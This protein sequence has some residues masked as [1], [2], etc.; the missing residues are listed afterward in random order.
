MA[1]ELASLVI[2]VA[3]NIKGA[4]NGFKSLEQ[5]SRTVSKRI[6]KNL[7]E[8]K[9]TKFE[10]TIFNARNA[11][12]GFIGA[13][14][15][16]NVIDVAVQFESIRAAFA[17]MTGSL[18]GGAKAFEFVNEVAS[19]TGV[20][21]LAGA[22][23][24]RML[25]GAA[26]G[27]GYT[28]TQL[29]DTFLAASKASL[30]LGLRT[31]DTTGIMRAF[32]QIMS[33]GT[34]Q[35]EELKGQLGDRLPGAVG[36]AAR[37]MGVSNRRLLEMMENAELM[38]KEFIPKFVEAMDERFTP[39]VQRMQNT[40]GYAI[41]QMDIAVERLKNSIGE[42]GLLEAIASVGMEVAD[43]LNNI[44]KA[45]VTK[46]FQEMSFLKDI[47]IAV[48]DIVLGVK[49]T[50]ESLGISVADIVK[51]FIAYKS[52]T[53][54][55]SASTKR[56]GGF[57]EMFA[58]STTTAT[59]A[60]SLHARMINSKVTPAV[61]TASTAIKGLTASLAR[62]FAPVAIGV[63][64]F[65][66]LDNIGSSAEKSRE[67]IRELYATMDDKQLENKIKTLSDNINT[68]LTNNANTLGRT[69]NFAKSIFGSSYQEMKANLDEA[70]KALDKYNEAKI[71]SAKIDEDIA[72]SNDI[73]N[74]TKVEDML[75]RYKIQLLSKEEQ[76]RDRLIKKF[77]K[78]YITL[79]QDLKKLNPM[80]MDYWEGLE[81]LEDF[82]NIFGKILQKFDDKTMSK[83]LAK[84][85][86]EA[87]K[88]ANEVAKLG[89]NLTKSVEDLEFQASINSLNETEKSVAELVRTYGK[90]WTP[91]MEKRART[92]LTI[93][94]EEKKLADD[95]K[96]SYE[97]KLKA[98]NNVSDA[99]ALW[100]DNA[101]NKVK[102]VGEQVASIMDSTTN[103]MEN[104]F[105]N[106]FD[107][108]SNGFL[109]FR[110]LALNV[111]NDIYKA[112]LRNMVIQP[113][114]GGIMSSIPSMFSSV[115]TTTGTWAGGNLSNTGSAGAL[116]FFG[117]AGLRAS[118]GAVNAGQPYIVGEQRPEL[119]IPNVGGRVVP[120]ASSSGGNVTLNITNNTSSQ[121][122]AKMVSEMTKTNARG[123]QE[124]VIG[125]V[126]DG[127]SRNTMGLR[128]I[129]GGSR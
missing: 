51:I 81:E 56:L 17:G 104:A 87:E 12:M 30:A 103:S 40:A 128:D 84:S 85:A 98:I 3:S 9:T 44:T 100:A 37:A 66:I 76:A 79:E 83:E 93:L 36:M 65:T 4:T 61:I 59:R 115:P 29:E 55:A 53:L 102:S 15:A 73:A 38:S 86:K 41:K 70:I 124:K 35:A 57:M 2:N 120:R 117:D 62:L 68:Y 54:L 95:V 32:G 118:G 80:D 5:T 94:N 11:L 67:Q 18:E 101:K 69:I 110:D 116:N 39:A 97:D 60:G 64:I 22:R 63:A 50:L 71:K 45:D 25:V 20:S 96:E 109:N 105:M 82:A 16:S 8:I 125:I 72:R 31:E 75:H 52:A 10:S 78:D 34:V 33:K 108:T 92:A 27:A 26:D 13:A 28:M 42:S 48:K 46:F 7:N 19:E 49:D 123:E 106:F 119:F 129:L 74:L 122:D 111:L 126:I 58:S 114:V 99:M 113:M 47:L 121:I 90:L 24:F 77:K 88:L 91:E 107:A 127:V 43:M 1:T 6:D 21:L 89:A 14:T 112:V 23:D